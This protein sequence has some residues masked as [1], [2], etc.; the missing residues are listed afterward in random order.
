M[1]LEIKTDKWSPG[2]GVSLTNFHCPF[3][4][5][6]TTAG[7]NVMEAHILGTHSDQLRLAELDKMTAKQIADPKGVL[8]AGSVKPEEKK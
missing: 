1:A 5:H 4:P 8:E 2:P 3:C 6:A 7:K